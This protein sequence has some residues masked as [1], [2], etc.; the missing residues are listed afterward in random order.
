MLPRRARLTRPADFRAVR[1]GGQSWANPL[2]VLSRA[3]N[4]L[5]VARFGFSVSRR[6]GGA[7]IRNRVKR[8]IS[9]AVRL[10]YDL[11]EPGWD[12]VLI[13]RRPMVE[14]EYQDVERAVGDLLARARLY[15]SRAC[16][17]QEG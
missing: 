9:E 7:V 11:V 2:L 6:L 8:R 17:G 4:A 12:V 16:D 14:A 15:R 13:A 1:V 5:E 3:P 10:Q